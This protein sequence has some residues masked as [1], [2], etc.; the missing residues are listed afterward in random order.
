[1]DSKKTLDAVGHRRTQLKSELVL[2]PRSSFRVDP[3][4]IERLPPLA[5]GARAPPC[6]AR[7]GL[8][9]RSTRHYGTGSNEA[10]I[11]FDVGFR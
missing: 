10:Y 1:M 3:P 7:N 2:R 5:R 11:K 8:R 4:W 6:A 9:G